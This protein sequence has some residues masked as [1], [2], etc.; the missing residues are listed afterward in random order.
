MRIFTASWFFPPATSAE[1]L[2]AFKLLKYSSHTYD[3]CCSD[4]RLWG[5]AQESDLKAGN[6]HVYPVNTDQVG[7]WV[8]ACI[9]LFQ[10]LDRKYHY[11]CL[12]TRSMP[13][14]SIL[15]G[16]A[17][18]KIH[19]GIRWIAS[20]ADPVFRN[21][22]ELEA[23]VWEAPLLKR[24]HLDRF[25]ISHPK[26][27]RYI[28]GCF[29][30]KKYQ[31]LR[32]L[33]DLEQA[34][35]SQAD[36]LVM[37][38]QKQTEYLMELKQNR[39]YRKKCCIVPHSYDSSLYPEHKETVTESIVVT[40]IGYLDRKRMPTEFLQAL[41]HLKK[42]NPSV[43]EKLCV[44]FIGNIDDGVMDA[45]NAFFLDRMVQVYGPV[46]YPESLKLMKDADYL[47]HIDAGFSFLKGGSIFCASKLI[48]YLGSNNKVLALTDPDSE[49]ARIVLENG[50]V[51]LER[52]NVLQISEVLKELL[53][54]RWKAAKKREG[55]KPTETGPA[56][57]GAAAGCVSK[58]SSA[59][60]AAYL[61]RL[62]NDRCQANN[63]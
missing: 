22:Y 27:I 4:S 41:A 17:V 26:A 36:L 3:V 2:V 46:S 15:V 60:I 30:V 21:P 16:M 8:K 39:K 24:L 42:M 6:I 62:L 45:A 43:V 55:Q 48:D 12:M 63:G 40:Y 51:L 33:Y 18:K 14:E 28:L 23:Y 52:G 56:E 57:E 47:L 59:S 25:F 37:P 32:Q 53:T 35:L 9:R 7:V 31:L 49:A 29:P 10:R 34:A 11:A 38:S 19:P 20:M 61:D 44:K 1:G 54:L 50:G 5:Y 58:Y 13:P